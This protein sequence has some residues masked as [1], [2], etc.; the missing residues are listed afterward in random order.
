MT[1]QTSPCDCGDTECNTCGQPRQRIE[2]V[3]VGRKAK[4]RLYLLDTET[5][6]R[7]GADWKCPTCRGPLAKIEGD[8]CTCV[9]GHGSL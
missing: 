6:M 2:L 9:R 7:T 8:K 1:R 4:Q 5:G 3:S